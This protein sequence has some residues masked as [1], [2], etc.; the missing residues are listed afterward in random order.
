MLTAGAVQADEAA[1]QG[2]IDDQIADFRADDFAGAF[3]HASEGIRRMFGTPD[4]FGRMVREGYP[5]VW[6]P[7][8]VEYLEARP[9]GPGWRQDVL[10][11][12]RDGRLHRLAYTMIET[13][14]G[15]RIAG[16]RILPAPEL[17]A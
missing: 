6:R 9:E 10:V 12:D 11:T 1:I 5:M 15:W 13:P 2:V 14:E 7:G 3:D 16:V 4:R 8:S 17:G